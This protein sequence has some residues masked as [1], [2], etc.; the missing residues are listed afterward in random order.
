MKISTFHYPF[1]TPIFEAEFQASVAST[2]NG[3]FSAKYDHLT[4]AAVSK[5][6]SLLDLMCSA[7]FAAL[8]L[9]NSQSQSETKHAEYSPSFGGG[10]V[11]LGGG[12]C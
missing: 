10:T 2:L 3:K 6:F 5:N 1:S 4:G 7:A 12:T 11:Q 8:R 9:C